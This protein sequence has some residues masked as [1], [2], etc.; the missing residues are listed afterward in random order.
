M[1]PFD[2][3]R[4]RGCQ[5]RDRIAIGPRD[6]IAIGPLSRSHASEDRAPVVCSRKSGFWIPKM[7]ACALALALV[8][9]SL[10]CESPGSITSSPLAPRAPL[11]IGYLTSLTSSCAAFSQ[12]SVRGAER[13]VDTIN[14]RGGVL[15]HSLRLLVRDD[16]GRPRVGVEQARDL[17]LGAEA[18]YLAGTCLGAVASR[19]AQ[20]VANPFH[21]IYIPGIADSMVLSSGP[22]S[23]VFDLPAT[24]NGGAFAD[25]FDQ[26]QVIA[27]GIESAASTDP[28]AVRNALNASP[29]A[30]GVAKP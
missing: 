26:I 12:A 25:G 29:R 4:L 20:L 7:A 8:L 21:M 11:R 18:K 22:S 27:R 6:R 19:V 17:V 24:A 10:G 3:P 14:Q 28:S 9:A 23:Y 30:R 16:R 15:G 1:M 2:S 5:I 13:A